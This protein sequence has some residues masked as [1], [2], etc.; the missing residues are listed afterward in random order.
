MKSIPHDPRA[1]LLR[2]AYQ[3]LGGVQADLAEPI[4][5][6]V[7]TAD[8]AVCHKLTSRPGEMAVLTKAIELPEMHA[9]IIQAMYEAD[10]PV[11]RKDLASRAGYKNNSRFRAA[12]SDLKKAQVVIEVGGLLRLTPGNAAQPPKPK[13]EPPTNGNQKGH[14]P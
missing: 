12:V 11:S 13:T 7:R 8:R 4:E 6:I 5:V 2:L 1:T 3:I 10:C 9:N 14:Q